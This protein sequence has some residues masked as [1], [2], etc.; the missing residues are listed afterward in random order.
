MNG[1]TIG[2]LGRSNVLQGRGVYMQ[3]KVVD[4]V[5]IMV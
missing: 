3:I 5:K 1:T 2:R 4:K